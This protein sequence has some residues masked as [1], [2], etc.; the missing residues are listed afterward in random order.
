MC[1]EK[2]WFFSAHLASIIF[3]T[4]NL[5]TMLY[6]ER[7]HEVQRANNLSPGLL[8][9][10]WHFD[11]CLARHAAPESNPKPLTNQDVV[12]MLKAGL[13]QEIVIAKINAST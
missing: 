7:T 5:Q 11:V 6:R 10:S 3:N 2:T 9:G 12:D 13:S 4:I 8:R 1:G